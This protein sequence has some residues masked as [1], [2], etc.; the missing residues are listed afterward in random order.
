M[1]EKEIRWRQ[2]FENFDK[3]Y[4][5]FYSAVSDFDNPNDLK[6]AYR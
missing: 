5:Q 3:A 1:R 2:R 6:K 4:E